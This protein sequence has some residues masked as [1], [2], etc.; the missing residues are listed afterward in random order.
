MHGGTV[1]ATSRG[2]DQG[3]TF[4]IRL[5]RVAAGPRPEHV[6]SP[7]A[8][9]RPRCRILVVEDNADAREML[10]GQL[11]L[12]GHEVHEASDGATAVAAI[13]LLAFD[14][15]LVDLGLPTVDGY[16]V[17]RRIRATDVGK[18]MV[19]IALTGYGQAEDRRRALEAGFDAHL[20]KPVLPQ[21]LAEVIA[22]TR[23]HAGR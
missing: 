10:R 18:S 4:R 20:T 1:E 17:A 22:S 9:E 11:E 23:R 16:E 12:E 3:S 8:A 14:L 5:P 7:S 21:R 2:Q 19:L 13:G 6:A 15:A